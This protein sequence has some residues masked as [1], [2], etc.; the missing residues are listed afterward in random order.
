MYIMCHL[1]LTIVINMLHVSSSTVAP[2]IWLWFMA[3]SCRRI[4]TMYCAVSQKKHE[5]NFVCVLFTLS[6]TF[7]IQHTVFLT[8]ANLT[9][10]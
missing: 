8:Y 1:R 7:L 5:C 2:G 6:G 3:K 10:C 9:S 4:K